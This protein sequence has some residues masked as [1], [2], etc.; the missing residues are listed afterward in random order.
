[1]VV[2]VKD[3]DVQIERLEL[4][5]WGTNAYIMICL[6]TGDSLVIDAPAEAG[7]IME[8]LQGTNHKYILLTHNHMDHIGA[9]SELR[10]KLKV[11]LAAHA[12]D[13]A[14]LPSPPEMQLKDGDVVSFGKVKLEVLHTPGHTSGSLCFKTGKYLISGDTIFPGGPGKTNA[15]ADLKQIIKSITD[16]VLVLSDDTEIY[17]GHGGSII[18][19]KERDEFAI[20]SSRPH[21]PNLCGDVLWLSS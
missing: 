11:P 8:K 9:L 15:P 2:V 20:F 12:A 5:P 13:S 4:G 16:K 6:Q 3:E 14:R 10:S 21:A 1:V 18:L 7:T 17:P 19:K